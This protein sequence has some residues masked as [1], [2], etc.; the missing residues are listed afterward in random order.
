MIMYRWSL[1]SSN[2]F[3]SL[4]TATAARSPK[5]NRGARRVWITVVNHFPV[6]SECGGKPPLLDFFPSPLLPI[7]FICSVVPLATTTVLTPSPSILTANCSK[8][9]RSVETLLCLTLEALSSHQRMHMH[10][11]ITTAKENSKLNMWN[12]LIVHNQIILYTHTKSQF[13][14]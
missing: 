1:P 13:W 9:H 14:H 12:I 3:P 7:F 10:E 6:P 8:M 5:E 11:F 4:C 2:F